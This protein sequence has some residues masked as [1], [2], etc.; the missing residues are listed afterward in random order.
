MKRTFNYTHRQRIER[1]HVQIRLIEARPDG[2]LIAVSAELSD[3][4][5]PLTAKAFIEAR[6]ESSFV[7]RELENPF[8]PFYHEQLALDEIAITDTTKFWFRV[9]EPHTTGRLLGLA[10]HIPLTN[11]A[12]VISKQDALLP[13]KWGETGQE[14]WRVKNDLL[15]GP[16]L[17]ISEGLRDNFTQFATDP[18][19]T[20]CVVPQAF[21]NVLEYAL[22]RDENID[23]HDEESWFF[24]WKRWMMSLS[25][26]R[27]AALRLEDEFNN[28]N[29]N[30]WIDETVNDFAKMRS[31]RFVNTV[32]N[33]LNR[34]V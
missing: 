8:D 21:R 28:D 2:A 18:M 30:N 19:F 11:P 22:L 32:S 14:I 16:I 20:G 31:N 23:L 6:G 13:V 26:L 10:D 12:D 33:M 27:P 24:Q 1:K 3:Y 4:N 34:R 17:Y 9:V 7:R 25:E 5:F 15:D 29:L